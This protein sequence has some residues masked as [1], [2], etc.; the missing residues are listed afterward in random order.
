[1]ENDGVLDYM[2]L[3]HLENIEFGS[4][5]MTSNWYA[6]HRF[7]Y[8]PEIVADELS[9]IHA[10]AFDSVAFYHLMLLML[11]IKNGMVTFNDGERS[12]SQCVVKL[13]K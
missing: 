11:I 2:V 6:G 13:Y 9:A 4:K 10:N 8:W 1:M 3:V 12:R 7:I 5:G